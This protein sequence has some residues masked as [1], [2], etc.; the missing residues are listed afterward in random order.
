MPILGSV[1]VAHDVRSFDLEIPHFDLQL[2][3]L[4]SRVVF[5]GQHLHQRFPR[6]SVHSRAVRAGLAV[7]DPELWIPSPFHCC[8]FGFPSLRVPQPLV[9]RS[10]D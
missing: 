7:P 4:A 9:L 8:F 10:I 6:H 1:V 2:L 3:D 5:V